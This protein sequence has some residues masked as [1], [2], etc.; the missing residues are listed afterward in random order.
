MSKH[1]KTKEVTFAESLAE[2]VPDLMRVFGQVDLGQWNEKG[3]L[4]SWGPDG[5]DPWD[6]DEMAHWILGVVDGKDLFRDVI[7]LLA[8]ESTKGEYDFQFPMDFVQEEML[9]T[10]MGF[11]AHPSQFS[12]IEKV[13]GRGC[14]NLIESLSLLELRALCR[15]QE[16]VI[17]DKRERNP[18]YYDEIEEME[19][20]LDWLKSYLPR[21]EEAAASEE[22]RL[23]SLKGQSRKKLKLRKPDK[24]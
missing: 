6:L 5:K 8:H 11:S 20:V 24:V 13:N 2:F 4:Y 12:G 18:D 16:L 10:A 19:D 21:L 23:K 22:K 3:Y 15:W 1:K 7:V 9:A 14:V 17:K